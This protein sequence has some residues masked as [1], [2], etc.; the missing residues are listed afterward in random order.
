M[1]RLHRKDMWCWSVFNERLN[2]DFNSFVWTRPDGNVVIDPLPMSAHDREHL[3]K[4]GGAAWIVIT[5]RDHVRGARELAAEF[6][7]KVAGPAAER[8]NFP[9]ACDAWLSEREPMFD[10]RV[11]EME[12]SKTPGELALLIDH[13]TS[14]HATDAGA[15]TLVTG[16]LVRAHRPASLMMLHPDQGLRDAAVARESISRLAVLPH[17]EAVLVGDGWCLFSDCHEALRAL[18]EPGRS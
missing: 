9:L 17:L 11:Y 3:K 15:A 1:K 6:G 5:N 18:T 14:L 13:G 7:A 4:L 16:D 12:G 2:I 8:A 10:W